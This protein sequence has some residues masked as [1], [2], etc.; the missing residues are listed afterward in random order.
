[1]KEWLSHAKIEQ[2]VPAWDVDKEK[3][4]LAAFYTTQQAASFDLISGSSA[5][6]LTA[7]KNVQTYLPH[8]VFAV[9]HRQRLELMRCLLPSW[10]FFFSRSLT[11]CQI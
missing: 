7:P 4:I 1:M 9:P 11:A 5:L 3:T 8:L 10:A 6:L 2:H